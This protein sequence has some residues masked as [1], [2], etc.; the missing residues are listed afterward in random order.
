MAYKEVSR[1]EHPSRS[2]TSVSD[3][4]RR[5]SSATSTQSPSCR[6]AFNQFRPADSK[7]PLPMS[8]KSSSQA[9]NT[10]R[11]VLR[12]GVDVAGY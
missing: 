5:Y 3:R 11:C 7:G 1:V 6:A 4:P 9:A 12:F 8:S 2:N 10:R